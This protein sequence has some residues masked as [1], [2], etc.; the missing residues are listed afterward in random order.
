MSIRVKRRR[1]NWQCHLSQ[2]D[3][4]TFKSSGIWWIG[5]VSSVRLRSF[6]SDY[7]RINVSVKGNYVSTSNLNHLYNYG[8]VHLDQFFFMPESTN[9]DGSPATQ[10]FTKPKK[11][12]RI[13]KI[14][15][16]PVEMHDETAYMWDVENWRDDI[17]RYQEIWYRG[18]ENRQRMHSIVI[19][20]QDD[21]VTI[22]PKHSR[23]MFTVSKKSETIQPVFSVLPCGPNEEWMLPFVERDLSYL[24]QTTIQKSIE[25]QDPYLG[26]WCKIR[27]RP[28]QK[29][30]IVDVDHFGHDGIHIYCYVEDRGASETVP[31]HRYDTHLQYVEWVKAEDITELLQINNKL[32]GLEPTLINNLPS[33]VIQ[34]EY[35]HELASSEVNSLMQLREHDL[36]MMFHYILKHQKNHSNNRILFAMSYLMWSHASYKIHPVYAPCYDN[37]NLDGYRSLLLA[38][39]DYFSKHFRAARVDETAQQRLNFIMSQQHVSAVIKTLQY[40]ESQRAIPIFDFKALD[41]TLSTDGKKFMVNV[42]VTYNN[43]SL[44]NVVS[45]A[46]TALNINNLALNPIMK[47]L[48]PQERHYNSTDIYKFSN[49]GKRNVNKF[50]VDKTNYEQYNQISTLKK[51]QSW[52]VNQMVKEENADIPLSDVF[53]HKLSSKA[54]M[55]YNSILGFLEAENGCSYGGFLSLDVGWGKTVT[56]IE[57]ILRQKGTNLIIAPLT[58]L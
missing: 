49:Y 41:I 31:F 32:Y 3:K 50:K 22:Q 24:P 2:G 48:L 6:D 17:R 12:S 16:W 28:H 18:Y 25:M 57:L 53:T 37:Y 15:D 26:C 34:V 56:M 35:E 39:Q 51:Y 8:H 1:I 46:S 7:Q 5:T 52:I 47:K 29:G 40:E 9:A 27:S 33:N 13:H 58:L 45:Y 21:V 19:N 4:V 42:D 10:I 23:L 44:L 36:Q 38:K 20:V 11:D 43:I 14:R 54:T 55:C 30:Y